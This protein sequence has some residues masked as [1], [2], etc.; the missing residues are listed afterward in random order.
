[1]K[2]FLIFSTIFLASFI[3]SINVKADNGYTLEVPYDY[4][5]NHILQMSA[6]TTYNSYATEILTRSNY[7]P[8]TQDYVCLASSS[9]GYVVCY[10]FDKNN[11]FTYPPQVDFIFG[12]SKSKLYVLLRGVS[13]TSNS[14]KFYSY[15]GS[16]FT[17]SNSSDFRA[18]DN[19]RLINGA[20]LSCNSSNE[21]SFNSSSLNTIWYIRTSINLLYGDYGSFVWN[22]DF[23]PQY[24]KIL[25]DNY[26][27]V[28]LKEHNDIFI[29]TD[30]VPD[31]D[32]FVPTFNNYYN[33]GNNSYGVISNNIV[34]SS[35]NQYVTPIFT[36]SIYCNKDRDF[37]GLGYCNY[38]FTDLPDFA[39]D[40]LS[41]TTF[42]TDFTFAYDRN[43][44]YINIEP[45]KY[46]IFTYRF[47]KNYSPNL[48]VLNLVFSDSSE[49][50][51]PITNL[52]VRDSG[53]Y[54]DYQL[55]FDTST[56]SNSG[57]LSLIR[58][59]YNNPLGE[60][61][62]ENTISNFGFGVSRFYKITEFDSMPTT[63][64]INNDYNV[65]NLNDI[66]NNNNGGLNYF[67]SFKIND[68][69][70]SYFV[71]APLR[72]ID[73][74]D[75]DNVCTPLTFRFPHSN[76]DVT[77]NCLQSTISS[78]FGDVF[79]ILQSILSGFVLYRLGVGYFALFKKLINPNDDKIEVIDL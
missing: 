38:N 40:T 56:I 3:F 66:K 77:I 42:V 30:G 43:S 36:N 14:L 50:S 35:I 26:Q 16:D 5:S 9:S 41:H 64:Q 76:Q 60:S 23:T 25:G 6:D 68:H 7:N 34:I 32:L 15:N 61:Y 59:F 79:N 52:Y 22:G 73:A 53:S 18:F 70:L 62:T 37:D 49:V 54:V 24:L 10:I 28:D 2:K 31:I 65:N 19:I 1:M 29:N 20:S 55:L 72:F 12:N 45:N 13:S 75:D 78:A 48:S 57:E 44:N 8:T 67:N 27:Q 33:Y 4:L 69:Q 71:T 58:T 17:S 51:I 47:S 74:I 39:F 63:E 21:C 46:Y 11:V